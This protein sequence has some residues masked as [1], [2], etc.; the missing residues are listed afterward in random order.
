MSIGRAD[1][2]CWLPGDGRMGDGG[3]GVE[4]DVGDVAVHAFPGRPVASASGGSVRAKKKRKEKKK[5]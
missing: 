1:E 3:V 2:T 4:G 5:K